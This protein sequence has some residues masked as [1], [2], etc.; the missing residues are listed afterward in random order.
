MNIKYDQEVD[1]LGKIQDI[2]ERLKRK[3]SKACLLPI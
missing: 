1:V 3:S 2:G